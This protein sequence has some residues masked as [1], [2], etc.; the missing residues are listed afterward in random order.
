LEGKTIRDTFLSGSTFKVSL[1]QLQ[2][3]LKALGES[4]DETGVYAHPAQPP[5][6]NPKKMRSEP[7]KGPWI[8]N[9]DLFNGADVEALMAAFDTDD[10]T[11]WPMKKSLYGFGLQVT[12]DAPTRHDAEELVRSALVRFGW[13]E[14]EPP[15]MGLGAMA[16]PSAYPVNPMY[17]EA[18]EP[19]RGV[20]KS[21][22]EV[23][24]QTQP[25]NGGNRCADCAYVSLPSACK[26]VEGKIDQDGSCNLWKRGIAS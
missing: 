11:D 14:K 22:D 8:V 2:K 25:S 6:Y 19:K 15:D 18:E 9:I 4:V 20:K 23:G 21:K 1:M 5:K 26:K 16:P 3:T 12:V 17:T 10:E 13:A 7:A 24:Y